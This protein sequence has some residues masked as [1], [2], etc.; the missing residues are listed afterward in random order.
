MLIR[1]CMILATSLTLASTG[2]SQFPMMQ[3]AFTQSFESVKPNGTADYDDGTDE[4]EGWVHEAGVEARGDR[5]VEIDN[6]PFRALMSP[7]AKSIER[8]LGIQ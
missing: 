8:N 6:D 3:S 7:K 1:Y 5:P 4:V 2:C